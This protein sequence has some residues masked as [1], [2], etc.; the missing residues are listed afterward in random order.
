MGNVRP[1]DRGTHI[2]IRSR[3]HYG[4]PPM[5]MTCFF[6]E[7]PLLVASIVSRSVRI[8]LSQDA[9]SVSGRFIS[10]RH[11]AGLHTN[12]NTKQSCGYD[13]VC[14]HICHGIDLCKAYPGLTLRMLEVLMHTLLFLPAIFTM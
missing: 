9:N 12:R 5:E 4:L 11:L 2:I 13:N 6:E 10:L 3:A 14:G 7:L 1:H 8:L